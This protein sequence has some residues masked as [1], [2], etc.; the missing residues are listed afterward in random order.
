MHRGFLHAVWGW[1][2]SAR[3]HVGTVSGAG[4]CAV[5][6][7]GS[8]ERSTYCFWLAG[9]LDLL[10]LQLV[11]VDVAEEGVLLDVAFPLRAAAQPLGRVLG[12]EL[13]GEKA[14]A[15]TYGV[16]QSVSRAGSGR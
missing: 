15:V 4:D 16:P 5:G 14:A 3:V 13:W 12:H 10:A 1:A 2:A 8:A 11:P 9:G 7:R 6:G